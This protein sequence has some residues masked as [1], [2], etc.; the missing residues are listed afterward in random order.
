M[1][2]LSM[3]GFD[4]KSLLSP[5]NITHWLETYKGWGWW[6]GVALSFVETLIPIIPLAAVAVANAAAYGIWKGAMLSEIGAVI[7]AVLIYAVAKKY[8]DRF[9]DWIKKKLPK[10]KK[11]FKKLKNK[12][13]MPVFF[14][15][16]FPFTPSLLLN[17]A[18]G[19]TKIPFWKF[20]AAVVLGKA[21]LIGIFSFI[22]HNLQ[23]WLG[24][25]GKL[26]MIAGG[27]VVIWLIGR[28]IDKK[29]EGSESGQSS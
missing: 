20:L 13:F 27:L 26:A 9:G 10:S 29:N 15:S 11:M 16:C 4:L 24:Q 14:L 12:G 2:A 5:E 1:G 22:G 3:D 8:G 28:F 21:V 23:D 6:P 25:P 7:G 19:I 18:A 17:M